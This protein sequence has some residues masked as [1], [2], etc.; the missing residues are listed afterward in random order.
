MKD[1]AREPSRIERGI[2]IAITSILVA[3]FG[4][5][6]FVLA[7]LRNWFPAAL[8]GAAFLGTILLFHRVAFTARRTLSSRETHVLAWC[9]LIIGAVTTLLV[10][11]VDG[12][13]A[14]RLMALGSAL[15]LMTVGRAGIRK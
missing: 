11:L 8:F 14:S 9:L 4:S 12:S 7:Y 5:L 1:F 3:I 6:C 13:T 15:M 2:A 10:V